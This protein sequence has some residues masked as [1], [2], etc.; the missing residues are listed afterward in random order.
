MYWKLGTQNG[1]NRDLYDYRITMKEYKPKNHT[2]HNN[3]MII[4]QTKIEIE[5]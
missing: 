2:Y 3:Q 5:T 1:L 4:V